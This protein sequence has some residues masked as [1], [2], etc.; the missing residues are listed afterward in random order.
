MAE[1][2]GRAQ[3]MGDVMRI[4]QLEIL[5]MAAGRTNLIPT[6]V[7]DPGTGKTA[8]LKNLALIM[9]F[10]I[11]IFSAGAAPL[12]I[13]SGLPDFVTET[14]DAKYSVDGKTEVRT[15]MWTM[16]DIVRIVNRKTETALSEGKKGLIV[17]L[18]D[19][20]LVDTMTQKYL[21][22]FFQNK[23]LQNYRIHEKA[24]LV[25]AMNGK[26]SAGLENF[27]SAVLNRMALYNT[28]F[29]KDFWYKNVGRTLHPYVASFAAGPNDKYFC[30]ANA[31]DGASPS[32][33]TWTELSNIIA[34]AEDMTK[35]NLQDLN[36]VLS[37]MTEARV[38]TEA[39]VEFMKHVKIFQKFDFESVLEKK[40]PDFKIT[41]D[42]GD[43]ILMAFII[44]YI[45]SPEDADYLITLLNGNKNRRTFISIFVQEFDTLH[46]GISQMP[47]GKTKVAFKRLSKLITD[48]DAVDSDLIDVI[49]D[50]LLDAT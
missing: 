1:L 26:D 11:H 48:E 31:T 29:D 20:H 34:D 49:V 6:L 8:S 36:H 35:G 12:E 10:E 24:H 2:Q 25:A 27:L 44:R 17:L 30:G 42:I 22:E 39:T 32:P 40:D 38:G 28:K 23:T 45:Q 47:E 5:C 43:Q 33:R 9:G 7:G 18:D 41:D 3:L 15:T 13:Y 46:T 14:M 4:M 50:S 37:I 16:S 19:I 21:F